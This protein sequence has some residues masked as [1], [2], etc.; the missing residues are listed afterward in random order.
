MSL[1]NDVVITGSME[2]AEELVVADQFASVVEMALAE[3]PDKL[4]L[5]VQLVDVA[6]LNYEEAAVA[7]DV[8][9]S[10]LTSRL[11]RA[12]KILRRAV[13]A[14]ARFGGAER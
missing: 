5:A 1:P 9:V 12:R 11:H 2:S 6:S 13:E 3:L 4:R 10:A 8:S 14:E 7:L